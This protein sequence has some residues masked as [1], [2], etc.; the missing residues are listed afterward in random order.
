VNSYGLGAI[1]GRRIYCF[2]RIQ[3]RNESSA[4]KKLKRDRIGFANWNRDG[5]KLREV[6]QYHGDGMFDLKLF[7]V[8]SELSFDK[9]RLEDLIL[10]IILND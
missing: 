4:I 6:R 10:K 5:W 9:I 3:A 7:D 2:Y 8:K 1:N